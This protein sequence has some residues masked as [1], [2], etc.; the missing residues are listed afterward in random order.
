MP[1]TGSNIYKRKDGRWEGRYAKG[2][3]NGKTAYGSVYARSYHEAREK[4]D[5]AKQRLAEEAGSAENTAGFAATG[6]QWLAESAATL[7]ESS[8]R[9]YEDLFRCY[10][11]PEF[12][13]MALEDITDRQIACFANELLLNGGAKRQGLSASTVSEILT[14]MNGIRDYAIRQNYKVSFSARPASLK[15]GCR[16]ISVLSIAEERR[17]IRYL[18]DDM[19]LPGLGIIL[20]LFTGLRVGELCALTWDDIDLREKSLRVSKTMLRL[21]SNGAA[22]RKTRIVISEPKSAC[23]KRTIPLPDGL[24]NLL[25]GY[26]VPGAFLLTGESGRYVEPRTMENHFKR[27]LAA[28][29]IPETN[30]HVTRHTFATRCIESGFDVKSLSEILGHSSV[31]ITMDLYV[32]PTMEMKAENMNRLSELFA[33]R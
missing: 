17:L 6:R 3:I 15:R 18:L 21:R 29:D 26:Y 24:M 33:V 1:R 27:A 32:H 31:A 9:K 2:T 25:A 23:A 28:C 19:S 12:G 16:S 10:I 20:C 30:F 8:L 22:G 7:K 4:L 13:E 5:A 11:L 14:E